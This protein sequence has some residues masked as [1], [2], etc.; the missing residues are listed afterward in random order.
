MYTLD[1][2]V[3]RPFV[4]RKRNRL[5]NSID[6]NL[7]HHNTTPLMAQAFAVTI[8]LD[9]PLQLLLNLFNRILLST[10]FEELLHLRPHHSPLA[11][12]RHT[13]NMTHSLQQR[14]VLSMRMRELETR[15]I[16]KEI[17]WRS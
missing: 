1:L 15:W 13:Q 4:E 11:I 14:R 17:G 10:L 5:N 3:Q 7:N 12:P 6:S 2:E 9:L 16:G 8:T